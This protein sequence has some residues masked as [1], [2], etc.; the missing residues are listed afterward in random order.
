MSSIT[1]SFPASQATAACM[2]LALQLSLR[3]VE[4]WSDLAGDD[5]RTEVLAN[6]STT[7]RRPA[8]LS[9]GIGWHD[10]LRL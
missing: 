6:A 4:E 8:Y 7:R 5:L 10:V 2:L 9:Y 1:K 3:P